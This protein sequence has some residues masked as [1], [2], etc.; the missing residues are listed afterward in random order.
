MFEVDRFARSRLVPI[1]KIGCRDFW[2]VPLVSGAL[3]WGPPSSNE[4]KRKMSA[5]SVTD[6][7]GEI[8]ATK[9]GGGGASPLPQ[10]RASLGSHL[11]GVQA[12]SGLP[13]HDVSQPTFDGAMHTDAGASSGVDLPCNAPSSGRACSEILGI[14]ARP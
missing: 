14:T 1:L 8:P 5:L 12:W 11:L 6:V 2:R 7:P 10:L 3:S 9:T 4:F 13:D